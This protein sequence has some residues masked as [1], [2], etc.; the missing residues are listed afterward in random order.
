M[1]QVNCKVDYY[2]LPVVLSFLEK[3]RTNVKGSISK[4]YFLD[5]LK[6]KGLKRF[7]NEIWEVLNICSCNRTQNARTLKIDKINLKKVKVLLKLRSIEH[8]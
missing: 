7:G 1:V 8:A 3:L 5:K 6:N 4:T 2:H